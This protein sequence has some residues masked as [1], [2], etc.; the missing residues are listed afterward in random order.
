M[1]TDNTVVVMYHTSV[2]L[3]VTDS[4]VT[5]VEVTAL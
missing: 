1:E 2:I 5:A 4:T 3:I